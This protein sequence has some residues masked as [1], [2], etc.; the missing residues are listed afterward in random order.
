MKYS[1]S[2]KR[3]FKT[4]ICYIFATTIV[5]AQ[6]CWLL[7]QPAKA[8]K[9]DNQNQAICA[10]PGKDGDY[11]AGTVQVNTYFAGAGSG[12]NA[13]STS[14]TVGSG[15]GA[16]NSIQPG[17][18]LLIIQMQGAEIDSSNT[19]AYGDGNSTNPQTGQINY[20]PN[21]TVNGSLSTNFIAG[22]FEYVVATN[23]VSSSGGTI[24]LSTPLKYSYAN[25]D[26]SGSS[27][28]GQKRFQVIR[29]PQ[30]NNLTLSGIIEAPRWDGLTGGVVAVDVAGEFKFV[31]G[32]IDVAGRGFRGGGGR[33]LIGDGGSPTLSNTDIVTLSSRNANASKAEGIAGTPKYLYDPVSKTLITNSTE[34]YPNGSYGRGAPGNA[35]GGGT[36]GR[37]SANDENSGGGGGGNGGQG[38]KGGRTWNSALPF[39]G[40]G[41]ATFPAAVSTTSNRLVMGGGGGAGTTNN[42]TGNPGNGLASS[43]AP[44]GGIV[45]VRAAN[46]TGT[47]TINA[48]GAS[49]NPTTIPANDASGGGGAGGSVLIIS[50]INS[51]SSGI[52]INAKGGNGGF[53]TGGGSPHGPGGGGGGGVVFATPGAVVNLQGGGPG[54]TR[55][56]DFGGATGGDGLLQPIDTTPLD[57]G[58]SISG[59][60][61][62]I[63]VEKKTSTPGPLAAPDIATYTITVSNPNGTYR[64]EARE[65]V[66]TDDSLPTGFTHTAVAITPVYTGG[67]TGPSTVTSTGTASKPAWGN[68]TI[69]AGGSV[70]ITFTANI[71]NGTAP[72]TYNNSVTASAKYVN[73][74][75]GVTT[76]P[77]NIVSVASTYNGNLATNTQEDVTIV[78]ASPLSADKSVA[79][80]EDVDKSGGNTPLTNQVP[81]PGDIL[82]YSIIVNNNSN[83]AT[84]NHVILTDAIPA[85]TTYVPNS[86]QISAGINSGTKTDNSNDDQAEFNGSSVVFRLGTGANAT[87]GGS[88]A[89][90]TSTTV[91]FRVKI[92]DPLIPVGTNTVSNQAIISSKDY[93][94]T[95][96]NDPTTPTPNDPTVVKIAPRLRL[97]KR[98]TGIRKNGINTAISAYNDLAT[99]EN[100]NATSWSVAGGSSIYLLGAITA[101]QIPSPPG[102]PAPQDEVE[103]TIYFLSDGASTAKDVNLCDYIPE[104]QVYVPD[105]MTLKL[106]NGTESSV[107]DGSGSGPGSGFYNSNIP[108]A[109]NGVNN[110]QGAV[111]FK[112]GDLGVNPS[113]YGYIRFRARV[114]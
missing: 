58:S 4:R 16:S 23:S 44:G 27:S 72:G 98:V 93:A 74:S 95:K 71:A 54:Q 101:E 10:V 78:L 37:P 87:T 55:N 69:P 31:N 83:S 66:I 17:D 67:A 103:Y 22:N 24:N 68:F 92:N 100:D 75:A 53:N 77:S 105:S 86:L 15:V 3:I 49:P 38:G 18:L 112:I 39:G 29:V 97:V 43:G 99:D 108:A 32:T 51:L 63:Q 82:E 62:L 34:G 110:N 85:N 106:G 33:N 35:G 50:Q 90:S 14:I 60:N 114:K 25:A 9:V 28:Q 109:C 30:Y 26:N 73:S 84:V 81:T 80:V 19:A 57:A 7:S 6:S 113:E 46:I 47:G 76:L 102:A 70:S 12:A 96:S 52:T 107:A 5:F 48:N 111:Y 89:P 8:D 2:F 1:C 41:G 42:S 40:D 59:A 36:D 91:K 21:G 45:M 56:G 11:I 94:N 64:P 65:V 104:N 88:M 20:A 13:G 61:C 79:L